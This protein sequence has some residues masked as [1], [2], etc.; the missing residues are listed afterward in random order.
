MI[1][2]LDTSAVLKV[3]I[4][5]PD[6]QVM[7]E[8]FNGWQLA[9]DDLVSS[10]LLHTE[11]HCAAQRRGVA[12]SEVVDTLLGAIGLIDI[13]RAHLL[14]AARAPHRLRSA[15]AIHLATA[16]A[17]EADILVTYD[18]E[19]AEA[20][21]REGLRAVAPSSSAPSGPPQVS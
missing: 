6:M 18:V 10:F 13:E 19:L 20:A 8:S 9:G 14:A 17:V 5:E 3:L 4:D 12:A 7:R 16:L 15:D 2:Y 21:T 1:V 11:M